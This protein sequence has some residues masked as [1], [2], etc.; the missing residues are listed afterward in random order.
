MSTKQ[1]TKSQVE[2]ITYKEIQ[3]MRLLKT[4]A[5]KCFSRNLMEAY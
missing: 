5:L 2:A 3:A 4:P 1:I